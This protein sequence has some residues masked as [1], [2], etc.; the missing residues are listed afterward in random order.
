M[1][2]L[3]RRTPDGLRYLDGELDRHGVLHV[4]RVLASRPDGQEIASVTRVQ[5]HTSTPRE[6]MLR[7]VQIDTRSSTG[8]QTLIHRHQIFQVGTRHGYLRCARCQEQ[9]DPSEYYL[10]TD[11]EKYKRAKVC[12]ACTAA[13]ETHR[14]GPRRRV[15]KEPA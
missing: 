1:P 4:D 10:V 15:A 2:Y 14:R 12:K 7:A 13:G 11:K 8:A 3:V 5:M 9:K 6:Q